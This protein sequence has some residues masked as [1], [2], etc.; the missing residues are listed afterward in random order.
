MN[1]FEQDHAYVAPGSQQ[2]PLF[3]KNSFPGA[4]NCIASKH[5]LPIPVGCAEFPRFDN[6]AQADLA[7]E[8]LDV[9]VEMVRKHVAEDLRYTTYLC[10][11][12]NESAVGLA[13][14]TNRP[15]IPTCNIAAR[16]TEYITRCM[17]GKETYGGWL[18]AR[19][20]DAGWWGSRQT[21][22]ARLQWL[23]L[24]I[25]YVKS[26]IKQLEENET[27]ACTEQETYLTTP[28]RWLETK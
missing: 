6:F 14:R 2:S 7:L 25:V 18:A 23:E 26:N 11:T 5:G 22:T 28:A 10:T 1:N 17:A 3:N 24:M 20:P 8:I 12:I 19:L 15:I 16:V 21:N 4:E 27:A 9:A 13:V